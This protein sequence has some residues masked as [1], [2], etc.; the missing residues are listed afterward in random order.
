MDFSFDISPRDFA[1]GGGF[2]VTFFC[3]GVEAGAGSFPC[4]AGILD[5]CERD[6][7]AYQ[8]ALD[9]GEDWINS[10]LVC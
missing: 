7:L 2:R 4:D 1:L 6:L 5:A 9:A 3:D 8:E 10:R